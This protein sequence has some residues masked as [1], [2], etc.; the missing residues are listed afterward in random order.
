MTFQEALINGRK[1]RGWSQSRL[2]RECVIHGAK[3]SAT[4]IYKWE[5]GTVP[6]IDNALFI[7]KVLGFSLDDLS[8][9]QS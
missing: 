4:P 6:T 2:H 1:E 8:P 9:S 3:F 7:S 5:E